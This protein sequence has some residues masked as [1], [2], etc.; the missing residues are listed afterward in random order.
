MAASQALVPVV[1]ELCIGPPP[2]EGGLLRLTPPASGAST[3]A[4]LPRQLVAPK[5]AEVDVRFRDTFN[6][7][8]I[9]AR[10]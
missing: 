8:T 1:S 2:C 7:M 9:Q 4:A 3:V 6:Y 10:S 5:H